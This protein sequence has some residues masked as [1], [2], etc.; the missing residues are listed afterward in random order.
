MT[1]ICWPKFVI[2]H[3]MCSTCNAQRQIRKDGIIQTSLVVALEKINFYPVIKDFRGPYMPE[4]CHCS[5]ALLV[6]SQASTKP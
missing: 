4:N 3:E 1:H 5:K 6:W 2:T